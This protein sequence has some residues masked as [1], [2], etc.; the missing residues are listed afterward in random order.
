MGGTEA[1]NAAFVVGGNTMTVAPLAERRSL[2]DLII[3]ELMIDDFTAAY[4]GNNRAP[5]DAVVDRLDYLVELGVNAVEFMPWMAWRRNRVFV[6][7]RLVLFFRRRESLCGRPHR[8]SRPVGAP[9]ASCE[10]MP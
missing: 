8:P 1:E 6:G 9:Q 3:Y 7:I 10:R 2:A 4:R 5:V